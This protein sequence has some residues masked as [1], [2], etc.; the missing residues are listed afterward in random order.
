ML[1]DELDRGDEAAD[2]L[3]VTSASALSDADVELFRT[4]VRRHFDAGRSAMLLPQIPERRFC[5][6]INLFHVMYA[7]SAW[8]L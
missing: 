5:Y 4:E 2:K 1:S 7:P 3:Q 6:V 8:K